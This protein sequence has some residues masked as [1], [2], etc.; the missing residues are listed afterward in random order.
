MSMDFVMRVHKS[1]FLCRLYGLM[2]V[3]METF[4]PLET[5]QL[6]LMEMKRWKLSLADPILYLPE[7]TLFTRRKH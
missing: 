6:L 3:L 5:A 2:P 4:T 1:N 7:R